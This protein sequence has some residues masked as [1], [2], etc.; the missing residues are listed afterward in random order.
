MRQTVL[1]RC[2]CVDISKRLE[3]RE[4]V[5]SNVLIAGSQELA[6]EGLPCQ[7]ARHME[8][9]GVVLGLHTPKSSIFYDFMEFFCYRPSLGQ[10]LIIR[11]NNINTA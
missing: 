8:L 3:Q 11:V 6:N 4:E 9:S 1:S 2:R 5:Q 7:T 10:R